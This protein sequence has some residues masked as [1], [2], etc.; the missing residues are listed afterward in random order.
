MM[1]SSGKFMPVQKL[2]KLS[3]KLRPSCKRE[4]YT[5]TYAYQ[6]AEEIQPSPAAAAALQASEAQHARQPQSH[7]KSHLVS[8]SR[9]NVQPLPGFAT[10]SRLQP[11]KRPFKA[12]AID[13]STKGQ[14]TS[15]VHVDIRPVSE[16]KQ[17]R[18]QQQ[19]IHDMAAGNRHHLDKLTGLFKRRKMAS[20]TALASAVSYG[21]QSVHA[22]APG[23]LI[24]AVRHSSGV[25]QQGVT[26]A[27]VSTAAK[28]AHL[29]SSI[30]IACW[31]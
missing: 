11:A 6:H 28:P 7:N 9:Q 1:T 3:K 15:A 12:L 17:Q 29:V 8:K 10:S 24:P 4:D 27:L 23:S 14:H 26:P 21:P 13:K 25:A 22:A 30:H 2:K 31:Q 20:K 19:P 18:Q 16:E 5:C